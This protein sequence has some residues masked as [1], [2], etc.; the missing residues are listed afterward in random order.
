MPLVQVNANNLANASMGGTA[1]ASPTAPVKVALTTTV[2][3]ATAAGTEVTGGSYARQTLSITAATGATAGSNS[4]A[5]TYSSMPAIASPGVQGVD[6]YDSAA[7]PV[8]L[9]TGALTTAKT[10]NAG[11]TFTIAVGALTYQIT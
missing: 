3:T 4:A 10:T 6:V 11:D 9:W 1:Y 7:T 2:G 5:L 8:R